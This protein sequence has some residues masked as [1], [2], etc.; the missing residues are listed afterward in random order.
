MDNMALSHIMKFVTTCIKLIRRTK[1]QMAL[2]RF[3]KKNYKSS[4][5]Y[6]KVKYSWHNFGAF[7]I[8][9]F[10]F[11]QWC[12][13]HCYELHHMRIQFLHPGKNKGRE[14]H[15]SV[16][17]SDKLALR[18]A[19]KTV[20]MKVARITPTCHQ[21]IGRRDSQC[22]F[23]IRCPSRFGTTRLIKGKIFVL[24]IQAEHFRL[25]FD[26]QQRKKSYV[27]YFSPQDFPSVWLMY[28][29]IF[30]KDE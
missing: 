26:R 29:V 14:V 18:G 21:H 27:Q 7:L 24:L 12:K 25:S 19:I 16:M 9:L 20:G 11:F 22:I 23:S 17:S 5:L 15:Y 28:S 1:Y 30:Q 2:I 4:F 10:F 8:I 3:K 6:Y 13:T